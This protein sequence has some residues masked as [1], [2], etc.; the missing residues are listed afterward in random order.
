MINMLERKKRYL[1][2]ALN[3]S[4][5]ECYSILRQLPPSDRI[6]IEAGTPLIKEQGMRAISALRDW[7]AMVT[8]GT[9]IIPYI[10]AD[11]KTMDRG[12]T[13]V[14]LSA[15]AGAS[16]VVAL[17]IAPVETLNVF[18]ERCRSE[19]LDSMVDMMNVDAPVKVLRR[20]KK[21]PDVVILH[22]GVDE[23]TFNRDKPIPYLQINKIRS[24]YDVRIS[25][26]GGDTIREVQRAIFNDA[27]IV[28]VWKEF[29]A[30]TTSTG[31]LAGEFLRV[32]K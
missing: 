21:L 20:L 16:A 29:F 10:A 17:G 14:M 22:R 13:E 5:H 4:L 7:W 3:G 9:G 19:K 6:I 15:R 28:V 2:I 1:Q 8:A 24:T 18:I 32:I 30:P 27:D 11:M 31:K 23:E 26:A 25:V 12:A